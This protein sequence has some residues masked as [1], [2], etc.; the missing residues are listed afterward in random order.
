MASKV[1]FK[2]ST[3]IG[4]DE[5]KYIKRKKENPPLKLKN[6][7]YS[8]ALFSFYHKTEQEKKLK[9]VLRRRD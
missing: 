4:D 7:F 3:E 5:I 1:L 8:L 2:L 9:H 6:D